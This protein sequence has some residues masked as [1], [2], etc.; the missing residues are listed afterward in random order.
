MKFAVTM[1]YDM[2]YKIDF[3]TV[4]DLDTKFNILFEI[5]NDD[6]MKSMEKVTIDLSKPSE[7]TAR[8]DNSLDFSCFKD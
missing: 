4:A 2:K 7:S 6:A 8:P 5:L 3:G 1:I